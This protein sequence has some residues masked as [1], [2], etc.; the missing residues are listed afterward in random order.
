MATSHSAASA[1]A[2]TAPTVVLRP[3]AGPED[4]EAIAAIA[5]AARAADGHLEARSA[6]QL[7]IHYE[8]LPNTD[9]PRD[10]VVASIDGEP[11]GYV[12]SEWHD[13]LSGER[14]HAMLLFVDPAAGDP[15]VTATALLERAETRC[16]A[17]ASATP[18]DRPRSIA[19]HPFG[20][21]DRFAERLS[22]AGYVA[23]RHGYTMRR[24]NLDDVPELPLPPGVELRPARPEQL[25]TIFA[26]DR[27][28]FRDHWAA[29]AEDESEDAYQ[30][31]VRDP[32]NDLSLW[33]IAWQGDEIVGQVRGYV[34]EVENE[35]T[36]RRL[37]WCECISTRRPWRGRGIA[38]ALIT[39]TLREF[40]ARGLT[41]SALTVDAQNP[42]GAVHLYELMGFRV[43]AHSVEWRRPLD[44]AAAAR[45]QGG[46]S[47]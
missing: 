38:R 30:Q 14:V 3:F 5:D 1:A 16:L 26:A 19:V 39:S 35:A 2:Q 41:E 15:A 11:A 34:D 12:R 13:E 24:P 18:T 32:T 46:G 10:L 44:V 28:A 42:T 8:H 21:G 37:G 33:R 23:V 9:L 45:Q 29:S 22:G 25:R 6:E 43:E 20:A 36:G 27:E 17:V 31:F 47:R 7:R 40:R 4:F